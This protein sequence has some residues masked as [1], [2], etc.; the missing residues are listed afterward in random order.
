MRGAL[1]RTWSF[2]QTHTSVPHKRM[3]VFPTSACKC[4]S[5]ARKRT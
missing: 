4:V 1:V 3:Q 5:L 2:S